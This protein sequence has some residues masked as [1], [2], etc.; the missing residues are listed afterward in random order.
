MIYIFSRILIIQNAKNYS[1]LLKFNNKKKLFN[2]I[3]FNFMIKIYLLK[4]KK[5]TLLILL[6]II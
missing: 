5:F 3:N 4:I 1:F 2:E 6:I